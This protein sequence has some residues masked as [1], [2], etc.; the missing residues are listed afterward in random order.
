MN[1]EALL[2]QYGIYLTTLIV[3]LVA[4]VL[5][6]DI[7]EVYLVWVAA[8]TPRSQAIPILLLATLGQMI[9]KTIFYLA[10]AGILKIS[11]KKPGEKIRAVQAKIARS[12]YGAG[13]ILFSSAFLGFPPFYWTSITAGIC[14]ISFPLFLTTGFVGRF[15]RF[16]VFVF[17]PHLIKGIIR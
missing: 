4:G 3:S 12:R 1:F 7:M 8:L 10:A 9:G 14:R 16:G 11:I 5:P 6:I 15:L 2:L 13:V 17:F